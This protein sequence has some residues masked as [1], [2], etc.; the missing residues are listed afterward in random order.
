MDRDD[1]LLAIVK[2]V[3]P[4]LTVVERE[5]VPPIPV[6]V[7]LTVT[8]KVPGETEVSVNMVRVEVADAPDDS[9]TVYV[10]RDAP[11]PP[12]TLVAKVTEPLKPF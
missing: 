9:V 1:G 6:P 10:L 4:T 12:E 5:I 2:P 11:G 8:V 3:T 7:P